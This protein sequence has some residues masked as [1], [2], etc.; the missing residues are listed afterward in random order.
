M[1]CF[2]AALALAMALFSSGASADDSF[3]S[4]DRYRAA[5]GAD[6]RDVTRAKR[7]PPPFSCPKKGRRAAGR[8]DAGDDRCRCGRRRHFVRS[9]PRAARKSRCSFDPQTIGDERDGLPAIVSLA[10]VRPGLRAGGGPGAR[11]GASPWSTRGRAASTIRT[12]RRFRFSGKGV[13]PVND[14]A[15]KGTAGRA[16]ATGGVAAQQSAAS[17][18]DWITVAIIAGHG[19]RNRGLARGPSMDWCQKRQQEAAA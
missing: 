17:G 9:C 8:R 5:Q 1:R 13:V 11:C 3:R 14:A 10:G 15:R 6:A 19:T 18:A 2:L 7:C 16:I 4:D 12:E